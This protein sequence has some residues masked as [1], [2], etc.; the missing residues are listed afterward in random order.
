MGFNEGLN[1]LLVD[2]STNK[3]VWETLKV[4]ALASIFVFIPVLFCMLC[5]CSEGGRCQKFKKKIETEEER[6]VRLRREYEKEMQRRD[7]KK[8]E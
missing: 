6:D 2:P 8:L 4:T 5:Y 3:V 1:K 7:N